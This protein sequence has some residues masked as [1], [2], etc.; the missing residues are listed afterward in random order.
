MAASASV[1][2]GDQCLPGLIH[3]PH[4]TV[5]VMQMVRDTEDVTFDEGTVSP[6]GFSRP[7]LFDFPESVSL[8]LNDLL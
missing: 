3:R 2:N 5:F 1:A 7:R 4:R 6:F 8:R